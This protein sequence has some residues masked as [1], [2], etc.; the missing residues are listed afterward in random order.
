MEVEAKPGQNY[1][2]TISFTEIE[3]LAL[4]MLVRQLHYIVL[5]Y[6]EDQ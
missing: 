2:M 1:V 3:C 4:Q 5:I 6:P